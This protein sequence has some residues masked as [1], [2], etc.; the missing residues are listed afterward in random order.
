MKKIPKKEEKNLIKYLNDYKFSLKFII[1]ILEDKIWI[2]VSK[3]NLNRIFLNKTL[4]KIN[5]FKNLENKFN[6]FLFL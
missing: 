6:I 5:Y 1:N 4:D 3:K 2:L